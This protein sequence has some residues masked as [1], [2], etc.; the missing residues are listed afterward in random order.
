MTYN[1]ISPTDIIDVLS[2]IDFFAD[3]TAEDLRTLAD[4]ATRDD[5]V[6]NDVLFDEGDE[7]DALYVVLSGRIAFV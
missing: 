1:A 7:P 2:E 3:A 6:R 5:M 4:A